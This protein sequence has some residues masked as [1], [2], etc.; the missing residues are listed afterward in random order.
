MKKL[1]VSTVFILF[2]GFTFSQTLEKGN[3]IG[4]HVM[5]INLDQDVTMNQ[6]LDFFSSK[7]IPEINKWEGW[8]AYLAKGIRGENENSFGIIYVIESEDARNK[9]YNEDG[10]MNEL[11]ISFQKEIQPIFDEL[12]KLGTWNTKYTDWMV[13]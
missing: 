2:S 9:Y 8:K 1:I 6:F 12:N 13:L 5:T 7:L 4:M 3:L 11:G 10:S